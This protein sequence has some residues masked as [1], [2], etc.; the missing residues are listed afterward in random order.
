MAS[1]LPPLIHH[2]VD[3]G[4]GRLPV[5]S[6]LDRQRYVILDTIGKGGMGAVYLARD[7]QE[8]KLVAIKE[9]SQAQFKRAEE[10]Q[11]A[12]QHFQ[13]EAEMLRLLRHD[14]LPQVYGSFQENKRSYLV[15]E[16]IQGQSLL[17]VLKQRKGHPL[18]VKDVLAYG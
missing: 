5:N 4:T 8:G 9:M 12:R 13:Q 1:R 16:Y 6:T 2:W 14:N 7:T 15:M 10:L 17:D 11:Q 18:P 3:F